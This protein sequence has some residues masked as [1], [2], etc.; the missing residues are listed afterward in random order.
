MFNLVNIGEWTRW[1]GCLALAHLSMRMAN[2][3]VQFQLHVWGRIS[4]WQ[5]PSQPTHSFS[6]SRVSWRV[7][8]SG[9]SFQ[10]HSAAGRG[11]LMTC[12]WHPKNH[13]VASSGLGYIEIACQEQGGTG[14]ITAGMHTF[15]CR[16]LTGSS[17]NTLSVTIHNF[18]ISLLSFRLD[19][20]PN[21]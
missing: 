14:W 11:W 19:N 13:W 9:W 7:N 20:L 8:E 3:F 18:L 21:T 10:S 1:A 12:S 4:L 6:P 5:N 16:V 17:S 15:I 2:S